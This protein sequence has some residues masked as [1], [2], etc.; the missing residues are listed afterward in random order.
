MGLLGYILFLFLHKII[1]NI[2]NSILII[3]W[4]FLSFCVLLYWKKKGDRV[5]KLIETWIFGGSGE[6][7]TKRELLKLDNNY[8]I[9]YDIKLPDVNFNI[10]F[11]VLCQ[12]GLFAVEVKH[13]MKYMSFILSN[14]KMLRQAEGQAKTPSPGQ[15]MQGWRARSWPAEP[16][17]R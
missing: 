12:K 3:I 9:F 6:K 2:Q 1:A 11:V 5:F 10:D 15:T 14:D 7:K 13:R 17:V 4:A 8:H 16:P